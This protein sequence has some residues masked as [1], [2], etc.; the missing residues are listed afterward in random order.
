VT[1]TVT[2][3]APSAASWRSRLAPPWPP[4]SVAI[5]CLLLF[6]VLP[7]MAWAFAHRKQCEGCAKASLILFGTALLLA[8]ALAGCGGG[9]GGGGG[10][11]TPPNAGTPTGTYTLTVTGT[12]H[13]GPS[14]Q[15][16]GVTLTLNV[17]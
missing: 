12:A 7:T 3:T 5:Q 4:L 15:S 11:I 10:P 13:A 14:T 2:T 17:N 8:L 1:V 6:L 16:H 9:G